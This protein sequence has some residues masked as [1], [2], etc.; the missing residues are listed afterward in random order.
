[1]THR[2]ALAVLALVGLVLLGAVLPLGAL[3][4]SHDRDEYLDSTVDQA[5]TLAR[6]V[7]A[8][9]GPSTSPAAVRSV[10]GPLH[11][12]GGG[13]ALRR[14]ERLVAGVGVRVPEV[15]TTPGDA[16]SRTAVVT[17]SGVSFAVAEV[18]FPGANGAHESLVLARPMS[19]V[20]DRIHDLWLAF[21]VI[22]VAAI[23]AAIL[24]AWW[25]SRWVSRPLARLETATHS[26]G[27]G[28]LEHRAAPSGPPE[29]RRLTA[30]FNTMADRLDQ[31]I[32]RQRSVIADVAHQL[33]TP[34][35]ALRLRLDLIEGS[36][37]GQAD[38]A[39]AIVEV[40]RLSRLVD[41][42][43][44]VARAESA[45]A[46]R[47]RVDLRAVLDER[48]SAW[49]P[50]AAERGVD[51]TLEPGPSPVVW[52]V[53]DHVIQIMD[54]LLANCFDLEPAPT[55]VRVRLDEE[56]DEALASV[57]D[58]GPGMSAKAREQAFVRFAT[59]KSDSGGTGLG[60]SIV[61]ALLSSDGG[62]VTTSDT[63]GGGL[64][65]AFRLP[66]A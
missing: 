37:D 9:L 27:S 39:G 44:A 32:V 45:S 29:V 55:Q 20:E 40:Q 12:A 24:V 28:V 4:A 58:N 14:D 7:H 2:I 41:G 13:L 3:A 8:R 63:P 31:M 42:L 46:T 35:A 51:L 64:T 18:P 38:L 65:V 47:A 1:M 19:P 61:R 56:R 36:R 50:L 10:L 66:R 5:Q 62:S 23:A 15:T 54:N 11:V 34:I 52:G 59:T 53:G 17:L 30:A 60:L 26:F 49:S 43:L 16:D 57:V 6:S 48:V 21:A 22:V 33:R 25:L